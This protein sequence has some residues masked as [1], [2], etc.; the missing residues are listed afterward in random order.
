M[1]VCRFLMILSTLLLSISLPLKAN[2]K[3]EVIEKLEQYMKY[4][5]E[6]KE[7]KFVI[8]ITVR[9]SNEDGRFLKEV[10]PLWDR[11][12]SEEIVGKIPNRIN[13]GFL[14]VYTDYEGNFTKPFTYIIACEV[15]SLDNIP[16][17]MVGIEIPAARYATFTAKGEFPISLLQTWGSIW[18]SDIKRSYTTDFELYSADFNP[19]NK[20]EIKVCVSVK[21]D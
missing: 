9:T 14:A 4:K 21:N 18:N 16:E 17:G 7:K 11:F 5:I 2:D 1:L 3:L 6:K 12:F 13:K 19:Q 15:S 20:P 10:P 8:G